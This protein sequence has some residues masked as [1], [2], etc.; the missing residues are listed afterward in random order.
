MRLINWTG[1]IPALP[2]DVCQTALL[3]IDEKEPGDTDSGEKEL[4]I[5]KFALGCL[6]ESRD[7]VVDSRKECA[8]EFR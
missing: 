6:D 7:D 5:R 3:T 8:V 2:E 1:Y 4:G